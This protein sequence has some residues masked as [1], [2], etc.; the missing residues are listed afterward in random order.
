VRDKPTPYEGG[1]ETGF[2]GMM[3]MMMSIDSPV[4]ELWLHHVATGTI[5]GGENLGWILSEKTIK[6]FP[7]FMRIGYHEPPGEGF[8][9][10][11]QAALSSAARAAKQMG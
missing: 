1:A 6:G 9:G 5:I 2:F 4:D 7:F 11:V 3:K 8:V 10:D